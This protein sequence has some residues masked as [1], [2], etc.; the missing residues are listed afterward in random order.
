MSLWTD[1]RALQETAEESA[2][3]VG[4]PSIIGGTGGVVA[5]GEAATREY[6]LVRGNDSP[7]SGLAY[8]C[9][10]G[11]GLSHSHGVINQQV[12]PSESGL[13][14][15]NPDVPCHVNQQ[16]LA[17]TL[18]GGSAD[19][20]YIS[21]QLHPWTAPRRMGCGPATGT[22][23][24]TPPGTLGTPAPICYAASDCGEAS[25]QPATLVAGDGV[26]DGRCSLIGLY[27]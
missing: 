12:S 4:A 11:N 14:D 1:Q 6:T 19:S 8:R 5:S 20:A 7:L 26:E 10:H 25:C 15:L 21:S 13:C 18:D 16:G 9:T 23:E 3:E 27:W 22:V 24:G 2:L 17:K